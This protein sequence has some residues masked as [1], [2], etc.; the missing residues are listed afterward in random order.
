MLLFAPSPLPSCSR[1]SNPFQ[2]RYR[3]ND[4]RP[5]SDEDD[6]AG[7]G[8]DS[9]SGGSS[10]AE[11]IYEE[12]ADGARSRIGSGDVGGG[13]GSTGGSNGGSGTSLNSDSGVGNGSNNGSGGS[14]GSG[15]VGAVNRRKFSSETLDFGPKSTHGRK[16][17][18]YEKALTLLNGSSIVINQ[19]GS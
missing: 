6:G 18:R 9:E 12:I 15:G 13:G 3:Y 14:G 17:S 16:I 2:T 4:E 8:S 10:K 7:S 19:L 5:P 11:N 1:G